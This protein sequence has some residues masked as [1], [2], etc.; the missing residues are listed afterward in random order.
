MD[1]RLKALQPRTENRLEYAGYGIAEDQGI[2]IPEVR[3]YPLSQF[4][5]E[6]TLTGPLDVTLTVGGNYPYQLAPTIRGF[7]LISVVGAVLIDVNGGGTRTV[8]DKDT[9]DFVKV[10]SVRLVVPAAGSV[11]FQ[12]WAE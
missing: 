9:W 7:R 10:S 1:S 12:Q 8:L 6:I 2:K 11:I 3:I 5:G 4:P